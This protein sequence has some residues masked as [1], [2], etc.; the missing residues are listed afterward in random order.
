MPRLMRFYTVGFLHSGANYLKIL[1]AAQRWVFDPSTVQV[2]L[3][4]RQL[5]FNIVAIA[6]FEFVST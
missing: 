1:L 3:G 6:N 4:A 2:V 5:R